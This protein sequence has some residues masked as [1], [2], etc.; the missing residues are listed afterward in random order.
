MAGLIMEVDPAVTAAPNPCGFVGW[1]TISGG[2]P[3]SGCAEA[4]PAKTPTANAELAKVRFKK[5]FIFIDPSFAASDRSKEHRSRQWGLLYAV[6]EDCLYI[7]PFSA[8]SI[9]HN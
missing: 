7:R 6:Q 5:A 8:P 2:P 3:L 1:S 9:V 4:I